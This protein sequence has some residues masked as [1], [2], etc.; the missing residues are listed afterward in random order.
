MRRQAS[1]SGALAGSS[2]VHRCP[3]ESAC[4]PMPLHGCDPFDLFVPGRLCLI[5]EHSDWAGAYRPFNPAIAPG[6]ALIAG[7]QAGISAEV[8]PSPSTPSA[9]PSLTL[10][11]PPD[12]PKLPSVEITIP[13]T[14]TALLDA[15]RAGHFFSY[16]AA[17]AYI[18]ATRFDAVAEP[19]ISIAVRITG[20]SLP[21]QKGLSS[22]AAI[23]VLV[24]KAF[25]VAFSL[26]LS[27][28][29]LMDAAYA[30]ERI[31]GSLCGRMDQAVA[32][33]PGAATLMTFDG[34]VTLS[35]P[36]DLEPPSRDPGVVAPTES[37]IFIV[38][39]DLAARKDTV[40]I[41]ASLQTAYP[42]ATS[43]AHV[44]LQAHLGATNAALI[45]RAVAA[46][47]A[48]D[49]PALGEVY[50]AWQA[51][52]DH[53]VDGI[54]DEELKAPRLREVLADAEVCALSWGGKGVGSQGDGTVQLVARGKTEAE[55]LARILEDR[56]RCQSA[57]ILP[58]GS[59]E[60]PPTIEQV[61]PVEKSMSVCASDRH[62]SIR[63]AVITAAGFGTRLFPASRAV[64]P[65]P[66][67]PVVDPDDMRAK[68]ALLVLVEACLKKAGLERVVIVVGPNEEYARVKEF[69]SPLPDDL[70]KKLKP[71]M[72]EYAKE[73]EQY[74]TRI[75]L[76]VQETPEGFG[77][78]VYQAHKVVRDEPFVLLLGDIVFKEAPGSLDTVSAIIQSYEKFRTTILGVTLSSIEKVGLYGTV[79]CK[80]GCGTEEALHVTEI[81]E[82]PSK[83]VAQDKLEAP[84]PY[85]GSFLTISGPYAF[86]PRLM[87]ILKERITSDNRLGGEI[88][89]TPAICELLAEEGARAL[90]LAGKCLDFGV[91]EEYKRTFQEF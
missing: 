74:A 71:D 41:L 88:Q 25:S 34:D 85:S 54:C 63:T 91:P 24:A 89:L 3:S 77:H 14:A 46:L 90:P 70:R 44:S 83:E 86:S 72:L 4:T 75:E 21:I 13:L 84:A 36:I 23:T 64:R 55:A 19:K 59:E 53:A 79:G 28:E 39:A 17:T 32:F 51:S 47:R 33:G 18:L 57:T 12:H 82:K 73:I 48:R 22:S 1:H 9:P 58:L 81:I 10:T 8:F 16:A 37:Q 27:T 30:G 20:A 56:L 87:G 68:P 31:T 78:A 69:F 2:Q 7:T 65:K 6:R 15:A 40:K 38:F 42:V 80:A 49:A 52:F 66:M 76:V 67:M 50:V 35:S 62:Q 11:T 26:G 43:A 5:G 45:D 61:V 60:Q 29:G